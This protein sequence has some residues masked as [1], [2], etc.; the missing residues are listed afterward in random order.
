MQLNKQ[1][2][3]VIQNI[4]INT[5]VEQINKEQYL[6]KPNNDSLT[7]LFTKLINKTV[8][9]YFCEYCSFISMVNKFDKEQYSQK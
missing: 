6:Q 9:F 1:M 2:T 3:M 4:V 8:V 5:E 7:R